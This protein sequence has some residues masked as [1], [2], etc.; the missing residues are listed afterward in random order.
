MQLKMRLYGQVQ[1]ANKFL[2]G[3][4]M[5]KPTLDQWRMFKAVVEHGLSLIHI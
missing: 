4:Q 2:T 3:F 1:E 5:A